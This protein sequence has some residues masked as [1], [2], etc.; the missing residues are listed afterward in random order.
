MSF[1]EFKKNR[2]ITL[3]VIMFL[4][5]TF[6]FTQSEPETTTPLTDMEVVRKVAIL[7]IE[8]E[9]HED[10]IISFK[11]TTPDYFITDKY[12]VKVKVVDKKGK[13]VYKKTFKNAFLYV[14]SNGQ[15]QVGKP[16]FNQIL[17]T[18]SEL[19]NSNIG[20][21]REKEGVY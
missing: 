10:V 15:I 19:T 2:K 12:K 7:D 5:S 1:K 11:S 3:L 9:I 20:I 17:I 14:F 18:K 4:T 16:N 8:G 13:S 21:I 6:A